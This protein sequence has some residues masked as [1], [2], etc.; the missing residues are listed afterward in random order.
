MTVVPPSFS[1][2]TAT[3]VTCGREH[4]LLG[5]SL[6][7][8]CVQV[9][10]KKLRRKFRRMR[11]VIINLADSSFSLERLLRVRRPRLIYVAWPSDFLVHAALLCLTRCAPER[12]N[13]CH[14]REQLESFHDSIEAIVQKRSC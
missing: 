3:K 1:L 13:G 11:F 2:D 9:A 12:S 5:S 14:G 4:L 6:T 10:V 7:L 8:G